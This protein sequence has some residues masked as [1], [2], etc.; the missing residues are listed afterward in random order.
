MISGSKTILDVGCGSGNLGRLFRGR[1]EQV[2]IVGLDKSPDAL[3]KSEPFY[4][5]LLAMDLDSFS[6]L[7]Y[8][9]NHFEAIILADVLEHLKEPEQ[10]LKDIR[11]YL[12]PNGVVVVSLPNIARIEIRL[13]LLLGR[14]SY[15]TSGIMDRTHLHFYTYSTAKT[16]IE[17]AG[18][19]IDKIEFTGIGSK[20]G[21]LPTLF[22]YQFI[23]A[24]RPSYVNLRR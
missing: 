17:N 23:F 1:G 22:S 14:F 4:D 24:A 19:S 20:V 3:L 9:E 2:E 15:A 21:L 11:R 5:R 12:T 7:P 18:Y 13:G 8:K 16:L 6:G 10:M